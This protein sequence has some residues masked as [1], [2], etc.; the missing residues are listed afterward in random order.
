M[1]YKNTWTITLPVP[2]RKTN[3]GSFMVLTILIFSNGATPPPFPLPL[4]MKI[5]VLVV[6]LYI[7]I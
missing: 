1:G 2:R 3:C 4:S 6:V 5:L 7:C